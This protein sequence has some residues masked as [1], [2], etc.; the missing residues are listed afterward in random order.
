MHKCHNDNYKYFVQTGLITN[1]SKQ[2]ANTNNG[3]GAHKWL[4]QIVYIYRIS[5]N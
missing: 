2:R 1:Y 5:S 4:L 3:W